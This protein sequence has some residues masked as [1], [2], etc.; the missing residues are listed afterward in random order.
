MVATNR[1]RWRARRQL[2]GAGICSGSSGWRTLLARLAWCGV[3]YL[4]CLCCGFAVHSA[5]NGSASERRRPPIDGIVDHDT[6][7]QASATRAGCWGLRIR[8]EFRRARR[9]VHAQ[10]TP[11]CSCSVLS[12]V[13]ARDVAVDH[14]S[15]THGRYYRSQERL[16][17][18]LALLHPALCLSRSHHRQIG[19]EQLH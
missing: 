2:R 10:C 12:I 8:G 3:W 6:Q 7:H 16:E 11:H 19:E 1:H 17:S 18:A 5:I 4:P 14:R 13:A 15:S 9:L